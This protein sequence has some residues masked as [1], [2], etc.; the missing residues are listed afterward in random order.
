M[1]IQDAISQEQKVAQKGWKE[2]EGCSEIEF[3]SP[4][5]NQTVS[6]QGP[7]HCP[8]TVCIVKLLNSLCRVLA[9]ANYSSGRHCQGMAEELTPVRDLSQ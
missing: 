7:E 4:L 5:A 3:S 6:G 1:H 8:V 2:I 9:H